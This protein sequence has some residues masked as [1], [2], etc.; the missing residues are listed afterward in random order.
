MTG[1]PD[2]LDRNEGPKAAILT[3]EEFA[4]LVKRSETD[5]KGWSIE[6]KLVDVPGFPAKSIRCEWQ[7]FRSKETKG[8]RSILIGLWRND[9]FLA[10]MLFASRSD[11]QGYI[12]AWELTHRIV[13]GGGRRT[14]IGSFALKTA[15]EFLATLHKGD[16]ACPTTLVSSSSRPSVNE[17]ALSNEYEYT[18]PVQEQTFKYYLAERELHL[19]RNPEKY[20]ATG[21]LDSFIEV[22]V[23]FTTDIGVQDPALVDRRKLKE[24]EDSRPA[25]SKPILKQDDAS[26]F[27]VLETTREDFGKF[28]FLVRV[29]LKKILPD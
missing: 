18:S 8:S 17:F 23:K 25:G 2:P 21:E 27:Q 16:S 13:A 19:L 3:P 29:D 28:P 22:K 14:G 11:S 15:E 1:S 20:S 4:G 9:E 24:F 10:H 26:D 12:Y 6:T 7:Y 5:G